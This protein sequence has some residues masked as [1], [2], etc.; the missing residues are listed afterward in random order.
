[1]KTMQKIKVIIRKII[2]SKSQVP[3]KYWYNKFLRYTE[4]EMNILKYMVHKGDIVLDIGANRGV[5]LYKFWKLGCEIKAFE[6]NNECFNLLKNWSKDKKNIETFNIAL[7]DKCGES[8]LII[9]IDDMGVEHDASASLEEM[10][11]SKFRT[12]NVLKKTLDSFNFKNISIIKIDV[13][14]HEY[15]VLKGSKITIQETYPIFLIEIEIRHNKKSFQETFHFMNELGYES[16]YLENKMLINIINFDST[17]KQNIENL[18]SRKLKYI[19]NFIFIHKCKID[20]EKYKEL[21]K[22]IK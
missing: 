7:S 5:Y 18:N 17:I 15:A 6:P 4:E 11:V 21:K 20:N 19:N 22:L 9:P 12:Q 13:E 16:Y 1:M 8:K 2:V 14:G 3:I 10:N